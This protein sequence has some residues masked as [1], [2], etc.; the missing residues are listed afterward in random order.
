MLIMS[1]DTL[2]IIFCI[3]FWKHTMKYLKHLLNSLYVHMQFVHIIKSKHN[4]CLE[5]Q[6]KN[7]S[8]KNWQRNDFNKALST[9]FHSIIKGLLFSQWS[10]FSFWTMIFP[11]IPVLVFTHF[12][13]SFWS[14]SWNAIRTAWR[15]RATPETWDA[16]RWRLSKTLSDF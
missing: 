16:F 13:G 11:D 12:S 5:C 8:N 14:F 15:T 9:V 3:V 2:F 7:L 10:L 6:Y 1:I 4:F